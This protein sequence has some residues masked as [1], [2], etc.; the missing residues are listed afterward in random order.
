MAK[1]RIALASIFTKNKPCLI[2]Y[3]WLLSTA[4]KRS[5]LPTFFQAI[6]A[7]HLL[8]IGITRAKEHLQYPA[9]GFPEQ[10]LQEGAVLATS[11]IETLSNAKNYHTDIL[12]KLL[13]NSLSQIFIRGHLALQSQRKTVEFVL[14]KKP[15]LDLTQVRLIY[16]EYPQPAGHVAQDWIGKL[17]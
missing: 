11:A 14:H 6:K 3:P 13:M 1:R 16:G 9:Y 7:K 12:D 10:F 2:E 17:R 5:Q 8:N 15:K 4:E